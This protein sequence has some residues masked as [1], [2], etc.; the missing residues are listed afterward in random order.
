M[1]N[2]DFPAMKSSVSVR[3]TIFLMNK[4]ETFVGLE[5][6]EVQEDKNT[7]EELA[8]LVFPESYYICGT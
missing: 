3:E 4:Y 8:F 1:D 6:I 2:S 7:V 5:M